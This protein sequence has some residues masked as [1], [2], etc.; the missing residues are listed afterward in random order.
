MRDLSQ[1]SEA[2]IATARASRLAFLRTELRVANTMLNLAATSRDAGDRERR[3]DRARE[4]CREVARHLA[5]AES[6]NALSARERVELASGMRA[7]EQR[8]AG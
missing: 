8:M 7:I 5:V 2:L 1:S 4:A 3:R 6:P